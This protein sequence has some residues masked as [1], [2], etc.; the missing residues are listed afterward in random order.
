MQME[1]QITG[2]QAHP[3]AASHWHNQI[4]SVG[5]TQRANQRAMQPRRMNTSRMKSSPFDPISLRESAPRFH[6]TR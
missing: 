1:G 4:E 6:G 3:D 2:Q 5:I